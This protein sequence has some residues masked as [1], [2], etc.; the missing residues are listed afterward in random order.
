MTDFVVDRGITRLF[1]QVDAAAPGRSK[2]SDGTVG[3]LD[4]Q[5]RASQHNPESPP[6]PGNPDNQVD[7]GDITHDPRRGAD[8][9]VVSEALRKSRDQR[10]LYVI[11]N[12]R[13]FSSY[14]TSTRKAWEW[15]EYTGSNDHSGHMHISVTDTHHDETQDWQIG[16]D[17]ADTVGAIADQYRMLALLTLKPEFAN[18]EKIAVQ[19]RLTSVPLIDLLKRMDADIAA[20]KAATTDAGPIEITLSTEQLAQVADMVVERLGVLRFE[21]HQ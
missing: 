4:H 15:G 6:P 13:I 19:G 7:A 9:G 17:M 3:D 8:M 5:A 2:A 1:A 20:I 10:I 16:I 21:A 14:A 12:G 18:S 11:F